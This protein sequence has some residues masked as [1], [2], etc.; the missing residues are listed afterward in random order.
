MILAPPAPLQRE[1]VIGYASDTWRLAPTE[2]MI[3]NITNT[4]VNRRNIGA[5]IALYRSVV[6]QYAFP[7][8][9]IPTTILRQLD[10]AVRKARRSIHEGHIVEDVVRAVGAISPDY[11]IVIC[12]SSTEGVVGVTATRVLLPGKRRGNRDIYLNYVESASEWRA[13]LYNQM[14]LRP[15]IPAP[16]SPPLQEAAAG[17]LCTEA[18]AQDGFSWYVTNF[19]RSDWDIKDNPSRLVVNGVVR[20]PICGVFALQRSLQDQHPEL[21]AAKMGLETILNNFDKTMEVSIND[22]QGQ[23]DVD[24]QATLVAITQGALNLVVVRENN[25]KWSARRVGLPA[26][27]ANIGENLYLYHARNHWQTMHRKFGVRPRP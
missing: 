6:S 25:G 19:Q 8:E 22:K 9:F 10:S 15:Q 23:D 5:A 7:A 1:K 18:M 17:V 24:I 14:G 16:K 27:Q 3:N 12:E 26:D 4:R 2:F 20:R 21:A 11:N 13:M